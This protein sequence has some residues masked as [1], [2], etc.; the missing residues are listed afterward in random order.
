MNKQQSH[1]DRQRTIDAQTGEKA[2]NEGLGC[3]R[4]SR[5]ASNPA[6]ESVTEDH[7]PTFAE[8]QFSG[9]PTSEIRLGSTSKQRNENQNDAKNE[10]PKEEK[11]E[12]NVGSRGKTNPSR[13]VCLSPL[14]LIADAAS[15]W[16]SFRFVLRYLVRCD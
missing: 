8:A 13:I 2:R 10:G 12:T 4:P 11:R 1:N 15:T 3:N 16:V 14:D 9:T 6:P 7:Q 5:S